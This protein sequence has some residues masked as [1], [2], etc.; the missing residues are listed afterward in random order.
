MP[1]PF[2]I[3]FSDRDPPQDVEN[4]EKEELNLEQYDG[5]PYPVSEKLKERMDKFKIDKNG[6]I[7]LLEHDGSALN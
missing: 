5:Q 7:N 1:L 2:I 3:D 6:E 4:I